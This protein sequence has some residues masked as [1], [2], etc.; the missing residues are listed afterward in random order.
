VLDGQWSTLLPGNLPRE[1]TPLPTEYVAGW[2]PEPFWTFV[3]TGFN[4]DM[5]PTPF[6]FVVV[7]LAA[8]QQARD[9]FFIRPVEGQREEFY[10][11]TLLFAK[12]V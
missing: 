11:A 2:A 3:I 4:Y 8:P 10:L 6:K 9:D 1:G 5:R 7:F 12:T